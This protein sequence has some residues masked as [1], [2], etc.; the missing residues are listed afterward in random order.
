MKSAP[1][2]R[3]K[4]DFMAWMERSRADLIALIDAASEET[5][6]GNRDE[7][8]WSTKDHLAHMTRW[9]RSIV[10][11]LTHRPRHEGLGVDEQTYLDGFEAVNAAAFEQD[12]DRAWAE[13]RQ[14]FDQIHAETLETLG[15]L[16]E[17]QLSRPYRYYLPDE[18]GEGDGPPAYALVVG[19]TAG[20]Y[21]EHRPWIEA[22]LRR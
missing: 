13:V 19:N 12:R 17:E 22:L 21:D 18:P 6:T 15:R 9:E 5:V 2:I 1:Q 7:N 20:H 8:G 14:E 16:S 4:D 3:S 10:Y 11:L